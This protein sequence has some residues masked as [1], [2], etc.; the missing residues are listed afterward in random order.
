MPTPSLL[1]ESN[2]FDIIRLIAA[3]CV[4]ISHSYDLLDV[5]RKDFL[6]ENTT[7]KLLF[8]DLGVWTFFLI[9]GYLIF[10]SLEK[11]S[12][13]PGYLW[14]RFVR[15][16][17]A[18]VINVIITVLFLGSILTNLG[19]VEYF[20][21]GQV[22]R[23]LI[24]ATLLQIHYTLPGV[25]IDNP[26]TFINGSL[27]TLPYEIAMYFIMFLPFLLKNR[28]QIIL[29]ISMLALLFFSIQL[30]EFT[31]SIPFLWLSISHL[32]WLGLLF[33]IGALIKALNVDKVLK[34][35]PLIPVIVIS[36]VAMFYL[37]DKKL[38]GLVVLPILIFNVAFNKTIHI[39]PPGD[40]SYGLYIY[41]FIIQ[42][43]LVKYFVPPL[44]LMIILS[45]TISLI[46]GILSWYLIERPSMVYRNLLD[47]KS[48]IIKSR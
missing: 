18:L 21:N 47:E 14:R 28:V 38:F 31:Y 33:S 35:L 24:N 41:G 36:I 43:I 16:Y 48:L 10:Q 25:F 3:A 29:S 26:V 39:S 27:W 42:Q 20:S 9:S 5:G 6:H 11:N 46:A 4:L 19:V 13:L 7:S 32:S 30:L 12:H 8:S 40:Y 17:P 45:T 2:N 44:L 23:Y 22:Y 1:R 15:I 37:P 34:R